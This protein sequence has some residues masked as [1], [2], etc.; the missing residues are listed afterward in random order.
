M[1]SK[2]DRNEYAEWFDQYIQLVPEGNI[3][4]LMDSQLKEAAA[5]FNDISDEKSLFRYADNK[6]SIKEVLGH[7]NDAERIMSYRALRFARGDSRDLATFEQDDYVRTA[8]FNSVPF[9]ELKKEF[10]FIRKSTIIMFKYL[11]EDTWLYKGF[12]HYRISFHQDH[13]HQI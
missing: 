13:N 8:V 12:L 4:E 1:N 11:N 7:I 6:W 9:E 3:V 5:F 2:P 10:R